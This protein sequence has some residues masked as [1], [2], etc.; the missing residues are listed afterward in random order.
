M[1]YG[2]TVLYEIWRHNT[3]IH[4]EQCFEGKYCHCLQ[5]N[6]FINVGKIYSNC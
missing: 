6:N 5:D 2:I 3:S 1:D 4:R